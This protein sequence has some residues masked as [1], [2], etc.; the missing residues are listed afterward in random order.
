MNKLLAKWFRNRFKLI[1]ESIAFYPA[2]IAIGFLVF[3]WAMLE[4]DLSATGKSI[5][6]AHNWIRL[7][8]ANTARSIVAT[9]VGGIISLTVFSFSMVMILL[10][11]AAS[12]MSNRVLEGMIGNRFQ[13]VTLGVYIGTIVYGLFL[14]SSIR[15]I[16]SGIYIPALSIYS[17]LVLTII[18]IWLFIYFLHYVTQS[19][20]FE[21]IIQ[22]VYK[23]TLHSLCKNYSGK[24]VP[25]FNEPNTSQQIVYMQSSDYFQ[26]L[27]EKA[28]VDFAEKH[29]GIIKV[30]HAPG[31]FLLKGIPLLIFFGEDLLPE[32]ATHHLLDS[33]DLYPGQPI[34]RNPVFGFHHLAEVAIKSLSPGIN[35][36][37]TAVLSLHALTDLFLYRINNERQTVFCQQDGTIRLK[38]TEL[39]VEK[40]FEACYY[41]I[42]DYGKNDRYIRDAML[43][44]IDQL[45]NCDKAGAYS[46]LFDHFSET[47]Q[48]SV[49]SNKL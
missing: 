8:D 2:I 13:Q 19:V 4:F 37:E 47:I 22:R 42:W 21:T 14:L 28:L 17:L 16:D 34:E 41:S 9:I 27:D 7:R 40:L 39:S 10:N 43:H 3:S 25:I 11:Q 36:P 5:K 12:Q 31:T 15:N 33:I 48:N 26:G 46:T 49:L 32:E 18:D 23:T 24:N 20:K 35:D 45:K 1:V 6:Q 38:T 29:N 30:L 44:M